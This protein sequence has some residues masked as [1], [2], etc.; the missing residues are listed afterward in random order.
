[1]A[2]IQGR[3]VVARDEYF[4]PEQAFDRQ[5]ITSTTAV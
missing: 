3:A 2:F 1:M 4:L 5:S